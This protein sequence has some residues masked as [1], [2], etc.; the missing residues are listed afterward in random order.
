MKVLAFGEVLFDVFG[1]EEKIGGAPFNFA[2]HM[3]RLGA[4]VELMSAIGRDN[5]GKRA[6]HY[7][8]Q[9]GVHSN[10]LAYVDQPTGICQVQLDAQ[11]VPTYDLVKP[12]AWDNIPSTPQCR[13]HIE[14]NHYDLLYFGS[15][16]QRCQTS[17]KTLELLRTMVSSRWTLFDCNIRLPHVTAESVACGLHGCT[18][19]KVSR[20]EA[21][22]LAAMGL[23]PAYTDA[24][25]QAWCQ[26]VAE[27]YGIQQV[28]LTLDK[29]GAAIYA[30]NHGLYL[31][32]AGEQ[33]KVV[34]T[35]G[36]GDSF[37]AG[38]MASQLQGDAIAQSLHK[39]VVLS[40]Q[41]VQSPG[42]FPAEQD[43]PTDI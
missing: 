33:V 7:M 31:E 30:A 15:L 10:L 25:R 29:D 13:E 38:Y 43:F 4:D 27:Q 12:A 16:S 32:H 14:R 42:I 37:A 22:V 20:E 2:A 28:M 39:A 40:S 9:Y 34:S 24:T 26:A 21:P 6:L 18:H 5:R 35:V 41:V 23:T 17:A 1:T 3:A 8:T 11:G 19:L 36:A